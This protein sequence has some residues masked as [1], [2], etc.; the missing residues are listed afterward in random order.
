MSTMWPQTEPAPLPP[1]PP[2]PPAKT[3]TWAKITTGV[4]VCAAIVVA[5]VALEDGRRPINQP[6]AAPPIVST[7]PQV[8]GRAA[9]RALCQQVQPMMAESIAFSK[10]FAG[11]GAPGSPER[12][13][14]IPGFR[15][16]VK[17]WAD[18]MQIPLDSASTPPRFLTRSLQRYVDDLHLY[19]SNIARG[20]ENNIDRAVNDHA[21]NDATV[22]L[23]GVM[24]TGRQL[25]VNCW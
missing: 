2:Q 15:V 6:Q 25:G 18:R 7:A 5:A 14:A 23:A 20:P 4:S 9:D 12:D 17:Q 11:T 3:P 16:T 13:A 8:D 19:A 21:W 1:A 24:E 22:A 10:T